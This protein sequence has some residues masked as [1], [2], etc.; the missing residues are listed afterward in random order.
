[1]MWSLTISM[2]MQLFVFMLFVTCQ[3]IVNYCF[4]STA[5]LRINLDDLVSPLF[6]ATPDCAVFTDILLTFRGC[7]CRILCIPN[8]VGQ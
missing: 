8:L 5:V 7:C 2:E 1:M 3:I 4:V 6:E